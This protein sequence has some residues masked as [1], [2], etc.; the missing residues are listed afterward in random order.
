MDHAG[1]SGLWDEETKFFYD[2]ATYRLDAS[3]QLVKVRSLVGLIPMYAT[4]VIDHE[5]FKAL[6]N[7]KYV[8]HV[9]ALRALGE[10]ALLELCAWLR[11]QCVL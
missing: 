9:L 5:V 4:L 8:Q 6:P 10:S 3:R 11:R 7:F 1:G 2:E